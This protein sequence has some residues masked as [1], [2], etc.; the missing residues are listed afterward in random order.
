MS[1]GYTD[2]TRT[3][4]IHTYKQTRD[5]YRSRL[6]CCAAIA[7][8]VGAHTNTVVRWVNDELG[9][10]RVVSEEDLPQ[11]VRD[12]ESEVRRLRQ[13]NR[14]LSERISLGV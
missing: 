11:R 14:E 13:A 9:R 3:W 12:L 7:A 6:E 5:Q 8:D 10:P 4:A 2:S 1:R